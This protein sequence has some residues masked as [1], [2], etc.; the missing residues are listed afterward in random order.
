[1]SIRRALV[2]LLELLSN[3]LEAGR[4]DLEPKMTGHAA[5]MLESE[6]GIRSCGGFSQLGYQLIGSSYRGQQNLLAI[7][8]R[9]S[10]KWAAT[11]LSTSSK[12]IL[13]SLHTY[14]RCNFSSQL[15]RDLQKLSQCILSNTE[16]ILHSTQRKDIRSGS[17]N[18][19]HGI[20]LGYWTRLV[21]QYASVIINYL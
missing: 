19:Q 20:N 3:D 1:M 12:R 10:Q 18:R 14:K 11:I 7:S 5:K 2:P 4:V 17:Y 8:W 9:G 13:L 16:R 6:Q 21:Y 15:F